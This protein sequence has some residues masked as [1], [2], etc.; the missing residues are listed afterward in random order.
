MNPR[1]GVIDLGVNNIN[2]VINMSKKIGYDVEVITQ[3]NEIKNYDKIILP[4]IGNFDEVVDKCRK[5]GFESELNE[6]VIFKKKDVLGICLGMQLMTN[7]SEE[8]QLSGFE[9]ING[10]CKKF[11]LSDYSTSV[12]MGWNS[13]SVKSID[14]ILLKDINN[15][16]RFYFVHSYYIEVQ[17]EDVICNYSEYNNK[18]FVSSF[19]HNNIF[20]VQFHPEKSNKHGLNI[21]KNFYKK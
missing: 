11:S 4:G 8:G 21:F 5:N 18:K 20:G 13:I 2:S 1:I 15:K 6:H 3:S 19:E 12:H 10:N 14:S 16:S 17:N 7:T 9:W